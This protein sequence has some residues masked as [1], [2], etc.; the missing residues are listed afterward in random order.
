MPTD[1]R[2]YKNGWHVFMNL[3][4]TTHYGIICDC[5]IPNS[6]KNDKPTAVATRKHAVD[7]GHYI[8]R[9]L[10]N[11][12]HWQCVCVCVFVCVWGH[13]S[14]HNTRAAGNKAFVY[15]CLLLAAC[16]IPHMFHSSLSGTA[17]SS[18]FCL[19]NCMTSSIC[20]NQNDLTTV[21]PKPGTH[22]FYT[23]IIP[24]IRLV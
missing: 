8:V 14:F 2:L 18:D 22:G 10:Y 5:I 3:I 20:V 16:C 11:H 7:P 21:L 24:E 13:I 17:M 23:E 1:T 15:G 4:S 9:V 12:A 6:T 19:E